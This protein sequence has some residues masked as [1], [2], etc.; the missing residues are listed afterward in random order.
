MSKLGEHPHVVTVLDTGEDDGNPFIV[1]R[2]M[3]GGDV[4]SPGRRRRP[5]RGLAR[6]RDRRRRHASAGARPCPRNHPPRPEACERLDRRRWPRLPGRF[7]LGD[8]R[9]PHP[10]QRG[11]SSARSPTC[12]RNRPLVRGPGPRAISTPSARLYQM[13]T[14]QPPFLGDDAVS[15]ISQHLHADPV[16]PSRHDP[17]VPEA[18]DRVVLGLLAKRRESRPATAAGGA[19][20]AARRAR[21]AAREGTGR[22]AGQSARGTG[23]RGVRRTGASSSRCGGGRC[24]TGGTRSLQLLVGEPGIGK[25]RVAE[26]SPPTPG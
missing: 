16:P 4:E 5:G 9:G 1:S 8:D 17:E 14:G 6:G 2:Y 20:G 25:T 23:R 10:R 11:R 19:R 3:P 18:L 12:H 7:R 13:L 22:A 24:R 15:I 26:E 21:R